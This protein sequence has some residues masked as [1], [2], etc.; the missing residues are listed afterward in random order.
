MTTKTPFYSYVRS[1]AH[2][3]N[4]LLLKRA[5]QGDLTSLMWP[6]QLQRTLLKYTAPGTTSLSRAYQLPQL[7]WQTFTPH[8]KLLQP[9]SFKLNLHKFAG[10]DSINPSLLHLLSLIISTLLVDPFN[11]S[12]DAD[13]VPDDWWKIQ[14]AQIL[15]AGSKIVAMN[16]QSMSLT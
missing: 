3:R 16:Y 15:K 12:L 13:V 9:S 14:V 5:D 8:P 2:N 10:S 6:T 7:L 11:N 1:N 4:E